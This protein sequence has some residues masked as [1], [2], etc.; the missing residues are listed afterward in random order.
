[1][2]KKT[3]AEIVEFV[4]EIQKR[5]LY[6]ELGHTSLFSYLTAGLG[7]TP[8]SAQRRIDA[9]RILAALPEVRTDLETGSLNLMQ[10][11]LLA[12]SVRQKEK[13]GESVETEIKRGLLEQLR[14]QDLKSSQTI[15]A[16]GLNLEVPTQEKAR[17][18]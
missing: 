2:E 11:S 17:Y 7:Y 4:K 10:I 18:H 6:L 14:N 1:I 15:L 16:E 3:T 9:A 5:R 13:E 12:Q 8:A